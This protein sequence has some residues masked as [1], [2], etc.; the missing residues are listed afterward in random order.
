MNIELQEFGITIA[1][2]LYMLFAIVLFASFV[3]R[4]APYRLFKKWI[5]VLIDE[6][7]KEKATNFSQF[8]L[9]IIIGIA[10]LS[11]GIVTENLSDDLTDKFPMSYIFGT[12]KEMRAAALFKE[13]GSP[14]SLADILRMNGVLKIFGDNKFRDQNDLA[15]EIYH[16]AKSNVY[17]LD[18]YFQELRDI[19]VR[20][21]FTRSFYFISFYLLLACFIYALLYSDDSI[22]EIEYKGQKTNNR[23]SGDTEPYVVY[24]F[25]FL[26][27]TWI[28]YLAY[29]DEEER[30]ASRVYRYFATLV[31]T[32][33]I[34]LDKTPP[35][36]PPSI[37]RR[38]TLI[39]KSENG[40]HKE[41]QYAIVDS[42]DSSKSRVFRLEHYQGTIYVK[43]LTIRWGRWGKNYQ[44]AYF[45]DICSD[46]A[47]IWVVGISKNWNNNRQLFELKE[48]EDL[49][50]AASEPI[51]VPN[52]FTNFEN[53]ECK[54]D[55]LNDE[56]GQYSISSDRY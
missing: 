29:I 47:S 40:D 22:G 13:E 10:A 16:F 52:K 54:R 6:K 5:K 21:N 30:F 53:L 15:N 18:T 32:D 14:P 34:S 37:S 19:E 45:D 4:I 42:K 56:W 39:T 46:D 28:S 48:I 3:F 38:T 11:L 2:G 26:L 31:S 17:R 9:F 25:L 27:L 23:K 24:T 36:K 35:M 51:N 49:T 12:E 41:Y 50:W 43:P 44:P 1:V 7:E 33:E 8:V 20:I 55:V